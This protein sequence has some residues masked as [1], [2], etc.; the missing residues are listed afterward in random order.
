V[1][2]RSELLAL[3]GSGPVVYLQM[4]TLLY[5]DDQIVVIDKPA[6]LAAQPGERVGNSVPSLLEAQLGHAVFPVHRL[7]KET[8]GC[9]LLARNPAA[10]SRW[11]AL[12][13]DR[14]VKKTYLAVC[15]GAPARDSGRYQDPLASGGQS[16]D[17]LTFFHVR[18]RFGDGYSLLELLLGTGRTHQI[19]RHMAMHGHPILGDDKY[20]DF[21]L[22]R[23]L[24]K[25]A[26][27]KT[28]MLWAW[29]LELPGMPL[30]Q[31]TIPAHFSAF[32]SLWP[33]AP[34][35]QPQEVP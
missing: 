2:P 23:I 26:G 24:K 1:L 3:Q 14:R 16:Q 27:L 29:R 8:A 4:L 31:S 28:L 12:L 33:D 30:V 17:A 34:Q 19:R 32:F 20:G 7:D 25:Q 22:N 15:A 10:A 18:S 9:M 13:A 6:G 35:I 21:S 11:S 5:E